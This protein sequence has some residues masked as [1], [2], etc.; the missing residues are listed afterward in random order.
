MSCYEIVEELINFN[1]AVVNKNYAVALEI[2]KGM[3]MSAQTESMWLQLQHS[4]IEDANFPIVIY[5]SAILGNIC[6]CDY[7]SRIQKKLMKFSDPSKR[8]RYDLLVEE[9]VLKL[10]CNTDEA[11]RILLNLNSHLDAIAMYEKLFMFENALLVSRATEKESEVL[12]RQQKYIEFLIKRAEFDT[13]FKLSASDGEPVELLELLVDSGMFVQ[14]FKF[15]VGQNINL[16]AS[17]SMI[18]NLANKLHHFGLYEYAGDL[19]LHKLDKI[20]FAIDSYV[21]G[22]HFEKAV[23]VAQ[24]YKP[25]EVCKYER[26]WG[27][28]LSS[29]GYFNEA[30]THYKNVNDTTMAM[31]V[32]L[33]SKNFDVAK[34]LILSP[35]SINFDC[36][37]YS[38][39]LA[40]LLIQHHRH[41]EAETIL[42]K[43]GFVD[44]VVGMLID[45]YDFQRAYSIGRGHEDILNGKLDDI[46]ISHAHLQEESG[47]I[48]E[49]KET[50]MS[51]E[52]YRRTFE[53][54]LRHR[55]FDSAFSLIL[56]VNELNE[57]GCFETLILSLASEGDFA[58]I[59]KCCQR[60]G[61]ITTN[62]I[63]LLIQNDFVEEA[64][65]F[66]LH[67]HGESDGTSMFVK[68]LYNNE[69]PLKLQHLN[70]LGLISEVL[71][72][73]EKKF[74]FNEALE[75]ATRF[76]PSR[77]NALK[78]KQRD[79]DHIH[80]DQK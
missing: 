27:N 5:C 13:I 60:Y 2:L 4:S 6:L 28:Y 69:G 58:L 50:L 33:K 34:S 62:C 8:A 54:F 9:S 75:I 59:E 73:L 57:K 14:A 42:L 48:N 47:F 61:Y 25:A 55:K 56:K 12:S 78:E 10:K 53:I 30:F 40:T 3:K 79:Q 76:M 15:V 1:N 72:F 67:Y 31:D 64:L 77:L 49:A 43:N 65:Q 80:A 37:S 26:Q 18:E 29:T 7:L 46:L 41:Q 74:H 71:D 44:D 19:Y 16:H 17:T 36:K 24:K 11:E 68:Q 38:K 70:D 23:E 51:I 35:L 32:A 63:E 22:F 21:R 45:S 20:K 66:S 52:Q 39:L